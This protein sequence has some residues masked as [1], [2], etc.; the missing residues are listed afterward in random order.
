M[1]TLL[2]SDG[3]GNWGLVG[4]GSWDGYPAGVSCLFSPLLFCLTPSHTASQTQAQ[5]WSEGG[6]VMVHHHNAV[7]SFFLSFLIL[8]HMY[9]NHDMLSEAGQGV[10]FGYDVS[11]TFLLGFFSSAES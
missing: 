8:S 9:I 4:R 2:I 10:L 11:F 6:G 5:S 3:V 7:R 1:I